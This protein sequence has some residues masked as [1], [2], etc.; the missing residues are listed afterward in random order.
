MNQYERMYDILINGINED[1]EETNK[2]RRR[3]FTGGQSGEKPKMSGPFAGK[4]GVPERGSANLRYRT[5][6]GDDDDSTTSEKPGLLKRITTAARK[7]GG[8]A[9]AAAGRLKRTITGGDGGDSGKP[10][11][12]G[13]GSRR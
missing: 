8:K 3:M 10:G 7:L 11:A 5:G 2:A 4:P 1:S 9:L 6:E 12:L 13:P